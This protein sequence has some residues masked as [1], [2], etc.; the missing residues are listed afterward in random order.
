MSAALAVAL[1]NADKYMQRY[2]LT[3]SGGASASAAVTMASMLANGQGGIGGPLQALLAG[4]TS[5]GS[6]NATAALMNSTKIRVT[7]NSTLSTTTLGVEGE[8]EAG[9]PGFNI[10]AADTTSAGVSY[11][12]IEFRHTWDR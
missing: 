11:L 7:T 6:A 3:L 8:N 2:S 1:V 5:S 4:L 10:V 9:V 12:T